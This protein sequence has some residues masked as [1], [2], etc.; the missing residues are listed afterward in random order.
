MAKVDP[1]KLEQVVFNLLRDT[2][3]PWTMAE[4][5]QEARRRL[6]VNDAEASDLV[7]TFDVRDAVWSLVRQGQAEFTPLRSVQAGPA[8]PR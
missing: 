2:P 4:I 7:N 5:E 8:V 6:A 3:A 1:D